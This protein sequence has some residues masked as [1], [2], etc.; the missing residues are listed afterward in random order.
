MFLCLVY[1]RSHSNS[2]SQGSG[3][4]LGMAA[5]SITSILRSA[6]QAIEV[7]NDLNKSISTLSNLLGSSNST[8]TSM[9]NFNTS[10]TV[11][12]SITSTLCSR[13]EGLSN[14]CE[15]FEEI[16]EQNVKSVQSLEDLL[17]RVVA[18]EKSAMEKLGDY[19][20]L[21]GERDGN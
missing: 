12:A 15:H 4:D 10:L 9:N 19:N 8:S 5:L 7:T 21:L 16:V 1:G 6:I 13:M 20:R 17:L 2:S 11:L 3:Y 14:L 18:L